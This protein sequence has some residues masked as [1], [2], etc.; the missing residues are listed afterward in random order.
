MTDGYKVIW[1]GK[2][3]LCYGELEETSNFHVVCDEEEDD[4]VWCDGIDGELTWENVVLHLQR[5]FDSDI[6]EITAI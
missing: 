2:E 4:G 1:F 5:H 3:T 6:V